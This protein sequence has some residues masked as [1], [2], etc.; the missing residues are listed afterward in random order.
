QAK[1]EGKLT[2]ASV[3]IRDLTDNHW[4]GI[5][6]QAQYEPA[7]L[8]KVVIMMTYLK[9]A[10]DNPGLLSQKLLYTQQLQND[11]TS[12]YDAASNLEVGKSYKV[13]DLI[14]NMIVNSDNG[15]K[16]TLIDA[17]DVNALN[18]FYSLLNIKNPGDSTADYTISTQTYSLLFRILFN[19]TYLNYANSEKAL[20]LLSQATFKD[21][22]AAGLPEGVS[23]AHK[24][25]E[26]VPESN[27]EITEIG[28]HD[29]GIIYYPDHPYLLCV[30]TLG[31]NLD[32]LSSLIQNISRLAYQQIQDKYK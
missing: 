6:E 29:C 31:K 13:D 5:N 28:L 24:F 3:Y 27:G 25:G 12:P 9:Q 23:V 17:I 14:K 2:Q 7:S 4:A 22:L 11:S 16:N 18:E 8:L 20:E 32:D 10:E 30:M 19:A 21:G 26:Y 1:N 15:A